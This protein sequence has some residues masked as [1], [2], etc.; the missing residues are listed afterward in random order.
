MSGNFFDHFDF[1]NSADPTHGFVNYVDSGTANAQNYVNM[2]KGGAYI[3][4]D[5][6]NV[7]SS[8]GRNSVR[9]TSKSSITKGLVILDLAH[10]PG[11]VA[12]TWPAL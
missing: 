12:G 10:M 5:S 1:F 11:G 4:V 2:Q 6:K 9:I 7:A 3:G 8:S